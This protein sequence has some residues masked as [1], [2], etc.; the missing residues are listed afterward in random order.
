MEIVY[1]DYPYGNCPVQA[2]GTINNLPFYFRAIGKLLR[3]YLTNIG[4]EPIESDIYYTEESKGECYQYWLNKGLNSTLA[5]GYATEKECIEFI[6]KAA[7][8]LIERIK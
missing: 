1:K 2:E 5:A 4:K 7:K 6:E 8:I 3:L